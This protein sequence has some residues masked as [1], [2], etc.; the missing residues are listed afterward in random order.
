MD[1]AIKDIYTGKLDARDEVQ[2]TKENFYK[3]FIFPPNFELDELILGDRF[4][5]KGYKGSGKTALL[6]YINNYIHGINANTIS[7]FL[8]FKEYTNMQKAS[9]NNV[10]QNF[11]NQTEENIIFDKKTMIKEQNF[12]YIWRWLF[13]D[14]FLQDNINNG[15]KIFDNDENWKMFEKTLKNITYEKYGDRTNKFPKNIFVSLGISKLNLSA[16]FSFDSHVNA[17]AYAAFIGVI[18]TAMYYFNKLFKTIETPYYIFVDELEAYF[19]DIN[20]FK[21]DLTML[22]DLMFVVK[23]IND[24]LISWNTVNVKIFCSVRTEIINSINKFI[25]AKELNKITSGYEKHL[26]WNFNNASSYK[27]PIFQIWLKR[28]AISENLDLNS[29]DLETMLFKKWFPEKIYGFDPVEYFLMNTWFRPR[30]IVRF[31]QCCHNSIANNENKFSEYV[32]QQVIEEYSSESIKEICE[33]LNAHYTPEK[34]SQ[35]L[36]IFRG[37]Q[38][39]FS[40]N[41]IMRRVQ[42]LYP[43][44]DLIKELDQILMDLYRVGFIGNVEQKSGTYAWQHRGNDGPIINNDWYFVV[45]RALRKNLLISSKQ[46]SIK[47]HGKKDYIYEGET[48]TTKIVKKYPRLLLFEFYKND[49][50]FKGSIANI[51]TINYFEGQQLDC[52]VKQ[53]NSQ[54]RSWE[55][56]II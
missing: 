29:E 48:Y 50:K 34:I 23:E 33:E 32:Y 6:Y 3:S 12:I 4:F 41:Q 44:S 1:I 15:F 10:A 17:K 20:I 42:Q 27:H 16:E 25:V 46:D 19:S 14:K 18:D 31:L 26:T 38:A 55:L 2:K 54:H 9:M 30:D 51:D 49:K 35:I 53:Y 7:S 36:L 5:I 28:I 47:L 21:R 24:I 37:F 45:H 52:L 40:Y 13:L 56:E 11:Y 39:Q 43:D 8:Y 22:R